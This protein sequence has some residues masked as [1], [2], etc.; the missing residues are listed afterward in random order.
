MEVPLAAYAVFMIPFILRL[1]AQI[2]PLILT[3]KKHTRKSNKFRNNNIKV[4]GM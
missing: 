2:H 4:V 1:L 3:P